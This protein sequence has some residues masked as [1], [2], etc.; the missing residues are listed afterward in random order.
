MAELFYLKFCSAD[1]TH[2]K[3]EGGGDI[4]N[5]FLRNSDDNMEQQ[6]CHFVMTQQMDALLQTDSFFP[7]AP[8]TYKIEI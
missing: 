5:N 1:Y 3:I 8:P 2:L 4:E 6:A 7:I